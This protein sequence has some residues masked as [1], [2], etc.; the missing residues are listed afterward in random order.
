MT[1]TGP[2]VA[3]LGT[4]IIGAPVARNLRAGSAVRVWNRTRSSAE[5]LGA[6][7]EITVC[8]TPAEAVAGVDIIVTVLADGPAVRAVIDAA[9]PGFT[10]GTLWI[11]LGTVGIAETAEFAELARRHG[12]DFVDAPVQGTK[13]PAEQGKLTVLAAGSAPLRDRARLV[14]DRIGSRTVW[15]S[16]EPGAATR[17]KLALNSLV[18]ALTHGIAESLSLATA[19]GIDP[20]LVLEVVTGGPLDSGFF[21]AKAKAVRAADYTAAFSIANAVKDTELILAAAAES[22]VPVEVTAAG[23]HRFRRAAAA[24]YAQADMAASYL[25]GSEAALR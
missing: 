25:T 19:F 5:S 22:G 21:Q 11:Q 17:L 24:G 9:A 20:D 18:F 10:A 4:G 16:D 14:F 23:L 3:V 12:L 13:Q 7:G 8:A 6:A 1:A 15:V 2:V